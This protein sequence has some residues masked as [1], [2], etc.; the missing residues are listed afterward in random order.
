LTSSK[1][2]LGQIGLAL[3]FLPN[4]AFLSL[5]AIGRTLWR[6]FITRRHLLEWVTSGEVARGARTDLA[7]SYAAMWFAPA[8][9]FASAVS[10]GVMQPVHRLVTVPFFGWLRPGSRGGSAC[11][12]N[13]RPRN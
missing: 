1:R 12:W 8:I 2:T 11:R 7:G 5:T 6:V 4:D 9:A 10:L 13:S 3:A